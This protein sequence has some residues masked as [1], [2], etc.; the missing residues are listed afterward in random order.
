MTTTPV[1]AANASSAPRDRAV[2][3][4]LDTKTTFHGRMIRSATRRRAAE[5]S[6]VVVFRYTAGRVE[7]PRLPT[8]RAAEPLRTGMGISLFAGVVAT[9]GALR[10]GERPTV[11]P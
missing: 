7:D 10:P 8:G 11:L 3:V 2:I 9:F 4:Y 1:I 6:S 5:G